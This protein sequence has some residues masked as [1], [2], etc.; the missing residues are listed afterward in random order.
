[1][2][3]WQRL[4]GPQHYKLWPR[5]RPSAYR[6]WSGDADDSSKWWRFGRDRCTAT[7]LSTWVVRTEETDERLLAVKGAIHDVVSS[8]CISGK[9]G[10]GAEH[11]CEPCPAPRNQSSRCEGLGLGSLLTSSLILAA[12]RASMAISSGSG[13]L[14]VTTPEGGHP[15]RIHPPI[16]RSTSYPRM[17]HRMKCWASC[18]TNQRNHPGIGRDIHCV[19][20]KRYPAER[21]CDPQICAL[22]VEVPRGIAAERDSADCTVTPARNKTKMKGFVEISTLLSHS[23][24]KQKSN[25]W[26]HLSPFYTC[27]HREWLRYA[28]STSQFHWR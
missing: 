4:P 11:G 2:L 24:P 23:A 12:A 14:V 20:S 1:M 7:T 6:L 18:G 26:M 15:Q 27:M 28:K 10:T 5:E 16:L 21:H 17:A 25:E 9:K 19:R 22:S 13:A 8:S 3:S